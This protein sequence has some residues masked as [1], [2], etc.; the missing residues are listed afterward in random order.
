MVRDI[1]IAVL[2]MG[3]GVIT[4]GPLRTRITPA[5]ALVAAWPVGLL[6]WSLAAAIHSLTA[7]GFSPWLTPLFGTIAAFAVALGLA[8]IAHRVGSLDRTAV[9]PGPRSQATRSFAYPLQV[10]SALAVSGILGASF[11]A[12]G[13]FFFTADS[14]G[15]YASTAVRLADTGVLFERVMSERAALIPSVTAGYRAF[16]GEWPYSIYP[17]TAVA[18]VLLLALL[19]MQDR[20]EPSARRGLAG[21][22][23]AL[24][25]A[26]GL[27]AVP[28]FMVNAFYVHSHLLT[29][30]YLLLATGAVAFAAR[31]EHGALAWLALA[32]VGAAG[33]ALARPDGF[34]YALVPLAA[35]SSI[36][37]RAGAHASRRV[38]ALYA[39]HFA[40]VLTVF[41]AAYVRNGVW[42]SPKLSGRLALAM[43]GA[44]IVAGTFVWVLSRWAPARR[45]A[46]R[47]SLA[48]LLGLFAAGF[49]GL[50]LLS[51]LAPQVAQTMSG[52]LLREG[53]WF[54]LWYLVPGLVILGSAITLLDSDESMVTISAWTIVAFFSAAFAVHGT[55]HAG[56]LG[57][58]DSFNRIAFHIVPV[59]F[60]CMGAIIAWAVTNLSIPRLRGEKSQA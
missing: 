51:D 5:I 30:L 7:T 16:G 23:S 59:V 60:L 32:G 27:V 13:A 35:G 39:P 9:E 17:L 19:L 49:A 36:A 6:C 24:A 43:I 2:T 34:V 11:S 15:G 56:H 29:A 40:L 55:Q 10:I 31:D 42:V 12:A 14:W 18:T 54:S 57:W 21:K 58:T 52:N 20:N 45:V 41:G 46:G 38:A 1:A 25:A 4:L 44:H 50:M 3:W 28:F 53:L 33:I 8:R 26:A 48:V 47:Y 22:L 37:L